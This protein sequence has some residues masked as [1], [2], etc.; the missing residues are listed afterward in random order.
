MGRSI[1][2]GASTVHSCFPVVNE[3]CV[4]DFDRRQLNT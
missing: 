1:C 2:A 4:D 3:V